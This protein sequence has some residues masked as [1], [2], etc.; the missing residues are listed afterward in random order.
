MP[1]NLIIIVAVAISFFAHF[2]FVSA[3][4]AQSFAT[5]A[6]QAV[7]MDGLTGAVLFGKN[8]NQL[9]A[10]ASM[11]KLMTMTLIFEAIKSGQAAGDIGLI[12]EQHDISG[13]KKIANHLAG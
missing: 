10:P 12:V 8:E 9:M 2:P 3:S 13:T 5:K 4:Y 1:R 6:K 11:S 7:I